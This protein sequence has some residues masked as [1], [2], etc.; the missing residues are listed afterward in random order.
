MSKFVKLHYSVS[1]NAPKEKVWKVLWDDETYRQWTKPFDPGSHAISDWQK[2]SKIH[3]LTSEKD[4]MYSIVHDMKPN[5]LMVIKHLGSIQKGVEQPS[6]EQTKQWEG[7]LEA[8]KLEET[9]GITKLSVELDTSESFTSF[10]DEK[11][12]LAFNTVKQLAEDGL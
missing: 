3:F 2:G 10:M 8:Y 1:I 9:G 4:G 11:F 7:A 12:P 5:E 6:S